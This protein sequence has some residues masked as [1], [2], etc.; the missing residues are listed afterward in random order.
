MKTNSLVIVSVI[1]FTVLFSACGNSGSNQK[2]SVKDSGEKTE[3]KIGEKVWMPK[4]LD[5]TAFNNGDPIKEA[6]TVEEWK[7]ACEQGEPAW[8]YYENN[9]DNG[10]KTGILYNW[11][12]VND[13]R[14]LCPEGWKIATE[15]DWIDLVNAVGGSNTAG[16]ALK[17][18]SGWN[19]DTNTDNRSGFT[20]LPSG[21]RDA[22]GDFYGIDQTAIWWSSTEWIGNK[23]CTYV[24]QAGVD[25][26][27]DSPANKD[28]GHAVRC[29]KE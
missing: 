19:N 26:C 1:T 2:N 27:I 9:P 10:K 20:A 25:Y 14:G 12:A 8:C 29:V 3:L 18:T 4:N 21:M 24:L 5:V 11:F 15:N 28:V 13:A 17:S 16:T 22:N 23:V 6:K 7:L